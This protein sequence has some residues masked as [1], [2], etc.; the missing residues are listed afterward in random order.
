MPT[1][2][3]RAGPKLTRLNSGREGRLP[4]HLPAKGSGVATTSWWEWRNGNMEMGGEERG[5]RAVV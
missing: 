2:A 1:N 5:R 3:P 4:S